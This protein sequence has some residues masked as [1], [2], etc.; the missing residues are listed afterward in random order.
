MTLPVFSVGDQVLN[1]DHPEWGNGL[2]TG[3]TRPGAWWM[4]S[5]KETE[6]RNLTVKYSLLGNVSHRNSDGKLRKIDLRN[7]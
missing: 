5:K 2:V 6:E 1:V 4:T 3:S 7:T